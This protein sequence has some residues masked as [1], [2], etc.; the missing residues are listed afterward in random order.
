LGSPSARFHS[1]ARFDKK[2]FTTALS[3]SGDFA[4]LSARLSLSTRTRLQAV[5]GPLFILILELSPLRGFQNPAHTFL[6]LRLLKRNVRYLLRS[7]DISPCTLCLAFVRL[8]LCTFPYVR[9]SRKC[10]RV[11]PIHGAIH[12][13]NA[14]RYD[15]PPADP[16]SAPL[17][18]PSPS[19]FPDNWQIFPA[20]DPLETYVF[21]FAIHAC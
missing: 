5:T 1:T 4:R 15:L 14:P 13:A 2:N 8:R 9:K 6:L 11:D 21:V 19:F 3:S 17:P 7:P 20:S 18:P 12:R 16:F 10:Q